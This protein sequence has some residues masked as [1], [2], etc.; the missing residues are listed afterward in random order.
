MSTRILSGTEYEQQRSGTRTS[1]SQTS[2]VPARLAEVELHQ[3]APQSLSDMWR[4][5][6]EIREA[7][8]RPRYKS[9][10]ETTVLIHPILYGFRSDT[11]ALGVVWTWPYI[12]TVSRL[13]VSEMTGIDCNILSLSIYPSTKQL[14]KSLSWV[15]VMTTL[16]C[17]RPTYHLVSLP[18]F[19]L[20]VGERCITSK[21]LNGC[22]GD[23]ASS[24]SLVTLLTGGL[25]CLRRRLVMTSPLG[26]SLST[27][28]N[29][30]RP[31][32]LKATINQS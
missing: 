11:R 29:Y 21:K 5:T 24:R 20:D 10:A 23:Y 2:I 13:G 16:R 12:V 22:E 6:F 30:D 3:S 18:F 15:S 17:S 1:R 9:R 4:F 28:R 32:S 27:V 31:M 7:Q 25:E 19:G 8:L 26:T 14:L